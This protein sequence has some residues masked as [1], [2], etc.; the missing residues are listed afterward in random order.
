[1]NEA[2][3]YDRNCFITLTYR[4]ECVPQDGSL[5]YR[6]F[7]LFMKRLRRRF[8]SSTIRFYM[9]GEYGENFGRPHFHACLFNFDFDDKLYFKRAGDSKM[10]TSA[11]L[12]ELW[13][14][15]F[16]LIGEVTF[17]SA[18]YVARYCMKKVT[19]R[20]ANAHYERVDE[21]TGEVVRRVPE[22]NRMSLRPGIGMP[23]LRRYWSDVFP[24]ARVV[25]RG[26]EVS[27]PRAY[28]KVFKKF[29]DADFAALEVARVSEFSKHLE[30]YTEARLA[31][32]EHVA[33]A[34]V[35][36]LRRSLT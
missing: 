23:W 19:G 27:A 21:S 24:S 3:L 7:Q 20:N 14:Y 15:G 18:A 34:R 13:P 31:V 29:C 5:R 9:C 6:D 33:A 16:A 1:M 11:V 2:S 32:R 8:F 4:D 25:S 30:D 28:V 17:E 35:A 26:K 22:F 10:Y 12:E 36:Q